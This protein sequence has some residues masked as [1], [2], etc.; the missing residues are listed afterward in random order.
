MVL[1][2]RDPLHCT[3]IRAANGRARPPPLSREEWLQLVSKHVPEGSNIVLHTDGA[4]GY[5]PAGQA[6]GM[7]HTRVKHSG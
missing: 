6:D 7:M 3:T 4:A 5:G 2:P 1:Y